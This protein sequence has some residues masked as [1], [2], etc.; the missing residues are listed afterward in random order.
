MLEF[1]SFNACKNAIAPMIVI[2]GCSEID[3]EVSDASMKTMK[4]NNCKDILRDDRNT[5]SVLVII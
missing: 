5:N 3:T 2:L 4:S 1:R